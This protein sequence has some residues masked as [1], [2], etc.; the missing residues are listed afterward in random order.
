MRKTC[1]LLIQFRVFIVILSSKKEILLTTSCKFLP[2]M[3]TRHK[4]EIQLTMW[5]LE[6]LLSTCLATSVYL[7]TVYYLW[8]SQLGIFEFY[9]TWATWNSQLPCIWSRYLGSC[10]NCFLPIPS[11][12]R[13]SL[14]ILFSYLRLRTDGVHFK[15]FFCEFKV[16]S[17]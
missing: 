17:R 2:Q 5:F 8:S 11:D 3:T 1:L 14:V 13:T 4:F 12:T 7:P 15:V 9:S 16:K 10:P 6:W